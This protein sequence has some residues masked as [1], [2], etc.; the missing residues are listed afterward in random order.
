MSSEFKP[1]TFFPGCSNAEIHTQY[2]ALCYRMK[3]DKP[4]ILLIT[5]RGTGRWVVPKGWP[6][7]GKTPEEA[8]LREAYEEAGVMGRAG[9]RPIGIYPYYKVLEKGDDLPTVVT[10]FPVRVRLLKAEFPE[11]D[12][13][14]RKWFSRKKAAARVEE[15]EL[16][17]MLRKF[18]PSKLRG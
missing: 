9:R 13:R 18:D 3:G 5:S 1:E 14:R 8:A 15:P 11:M 7:S 10:L 6:M 2:A 4:Q 16:A 17:R 12:Q